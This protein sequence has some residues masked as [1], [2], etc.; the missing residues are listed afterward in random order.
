[1]EYLKNFINGAYHAPVSGQY[2]DNVNPATGEVYSQIPRSG[3]D[4]LTM[5]VT[6]A[7]RAFPLWSGMSVNERSTIL[8]RLAAGIEARMDEFVVAES[9]DNGKPEKL[10]SHV[11]IPRAVSNFHF[12]ATAIEHF[13][14]ESHYMD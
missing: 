12:F 13:S 6:A 10:A 4:D 8:L 5:A 9:R 1:M 3:A 7:E 2:L 14:S 11:D